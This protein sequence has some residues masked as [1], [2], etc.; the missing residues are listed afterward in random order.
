MLRTITHLLAALSAIL[1]VGCVS[2]QRQAVENPCLPPGVSSAIFGWP[3]V[4]AELTTIQ[5]DGG[6][7]VPG[8]VIYYRQGDRAVVAVW[9]RGGLVVVDPAPDTP[10]PGWADLRLMT[11]DGTLRAEPRGECE[12][13]RLGGQTVRGI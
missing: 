10:Q 11:P 1:M 9:S 7:P 8:V 4:Y 12:W 3:V 6:R 5:T 13:H 2:V